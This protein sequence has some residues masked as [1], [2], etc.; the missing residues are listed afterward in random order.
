MKNNKMIYS[1]Y[2][3]TMIPA[4]FTTQKVLIDRRGDEGY[5]ICKPMHYS[6]NEEDLL[7]YSDD[8]DD[9]AYDEIPTNGFKSYTLKLGKRARVMVKLD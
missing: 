7:Y 2:M 3:G 9:R 8:V 5:K 1:D 4:G 6:W